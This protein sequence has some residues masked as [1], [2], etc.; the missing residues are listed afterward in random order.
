VSDK[1]LSAWVRD[2]Q[3]ALWREL[4]E[5]I[6]RAINGA[7]SM[8]VADVA[9]RIVQ[10]A[11]LVGPTPPDEVLWTLTGSGIYDALLKV[12]EVEHEPLTPEYLRETEQ[13]MRDHG[14]TQEALHAQFSRTISAMTEPSEAHYIRDVEV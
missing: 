6:G 7:W 12:G 5:A 8:Q 13:R 11:R 14:G 2:E 1:A 9:R 4:D 10:A 3:D